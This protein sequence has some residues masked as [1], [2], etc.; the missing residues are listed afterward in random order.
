[1]LDV[2]SFFNVFVIAVVNRARFVIESEELEDFA[3]HRFG[4]GHQIFV[5]DVVDR[6]RR[7]AQKVRNRRNVTPRNRI[8][9]VRGLVVAV[10]ERLREGTEHGS[11]GP[12][13]SPGSRPFRSHCPAN[14]DTLSRRHDLA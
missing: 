3:Q 10:E 9:L 8:V 14:P 13:E 2:L 6:N 5:D 7:L 4:I 11:P 12:F 1:M